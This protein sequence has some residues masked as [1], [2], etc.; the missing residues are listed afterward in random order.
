[1]GIFIFLSMLKSHSYIHKKEAE[2]QCVSTSSSILSNLN[3][4]S[5]VFPAGFSMPSL[6]ARSS[7]RSILKSR[8]GCVENN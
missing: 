5:A 7:M 8:S 3:S 1:M 2:S 4:Y 6:V